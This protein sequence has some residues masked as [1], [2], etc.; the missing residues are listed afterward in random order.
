[1]TYLDIAKKAKEAKKAPAPTGLTSLNSLTS[2]HLENRKTHPAECPG[3]G[4]LNL[5]RWLGALIRCACGRRYIRPA[6]RL[7]LDEEPS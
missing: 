6:G 7:A 4:R 5:G 1:M 2:Q 3:C